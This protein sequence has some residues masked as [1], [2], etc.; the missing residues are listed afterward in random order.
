MVSKVERETLMG[1]WREMRR[2][3]LGVVLSVEAWGLGMWGIGQK[4]EA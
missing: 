4:G 3:S 1:Y 2:L